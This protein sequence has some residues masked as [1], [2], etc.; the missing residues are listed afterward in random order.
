MTDAAPAVTLVADENVDRSLID[1]LR[2]DGFGVFA[3]VEQAAGESD[4]EVLRHAVADGGVLLTGDR[5]F[6][7]LVFRD[8]ESSAGVLYLRLDALS[9]SAR[10]NL[11]VEFLASRAADLRGRFCV[12][13]PGGPRFRDAPAGADDPAAPEVD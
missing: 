3:V 1:R 13:T 6:G 12:L 4:G 11:V 9:P 8:G 5:D 2:A 10:D 7:G